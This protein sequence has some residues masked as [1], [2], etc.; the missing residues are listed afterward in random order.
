MSIMSLNVRGL[1]LTQ[2]R[3]SLKSLINL[4]NLEIELI[5]EIMTTKDKTWGYLL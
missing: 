4:H 5:Q 3:I 1:G 2:K